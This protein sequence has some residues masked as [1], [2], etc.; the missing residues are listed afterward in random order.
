MSPTPL[1]APH[2]GPAGPDGHEDGYRGPATLVIDG[3]EHPVS[4]LLRGHFQP[5]D[6]RYH[7]YGRLGADPELV[8]RLGG[9]RVAAVLRTAEG[10][11][12]GELSDP[13][14]WHRYRITGTQ[15][16]PFRIAGPGPE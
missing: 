2:A 5:I 13:D 8:E 14:P 15:A 12:S 16:P 7:W 3:V 11:A 4:V 6:G 9:G 1:P 10:E